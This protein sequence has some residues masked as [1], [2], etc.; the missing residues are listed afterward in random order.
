[1][2]T[3]ARPLTVLI[4]ALGGE[5]GGVLT[6]W[7]VAAANHCGFPAQST[8]IPGVAQRTGATTYYVEIVPVT[9]DQL[10][11]QR[12]VLSLQP[13]IGDVDVLL[14]SE[15][16]EAGRAIG[17][18]FVTPDRT[19]VIA[20]TSR[21]YLVVEK[22]AMA[23]GRYDS[24][25]LTKAIEDH[26]KQRVLFDMEALA[27]TSGTIVNAVM[28]GAIAGSGKLPIPVDAYEAAIRADGKAIEG[29]LRGFRAGFEAAQHAAN[30]VPAAK[31]KH[32]AVAK[33]LAALE[34]EVA[35]WPSAAREFLIEGVRRS[36][37]YQD[38]AYARLYL[39]RLAPIRAADEQGNV[40]GK[41]LREVA[42]HLAVRMSYED[43]IKVAEA[44]IHPARMR[45]IVGELKAAP[46]EPIVVAEFLKPGIEEMCQI[47]PPWLAPLILRLAERRG[48][49]GRV[50]FGM[51]VKTTSITGYLRVYMLAKLKR[52]RRGTWRYRQEQHAIES[53]LDMI[54][55]AAKLSPALAIEVVECARL[56]K[57]YGDTHQ[58]GSGNF[59]QIEQRIIRPV[60]AG[61][62]PTRN[63]I[64][65][66]ASARTAAL[67]DPEGESLA[68]C[69]AEI[70]SQAPL[71]I[72]AE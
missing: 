24:A 32:A 41:L 51:E 5:G 60:L 7:I 30:A 6:D 12:P 57:G 9:H 46:N 55:Q 48:W 52:W 59:A 37:R 44:K 40:G 4:A 69:L 2:T 39:D 71:R 21:S 67:T 19:T 42:R 17:N 65:A 11:G 16:M 68:K 26:A 54:A 20:S 53:W 62:M 28:L 29:N 14:A 27:K 23:D 13:G 66:I 22:M 38:A 34:C 33:Y 18:G 70:E 36:A 49:L 1:M 25:R 58:R 63:G 35:S 50:Y 61:R 64:D 3:L 15:L 47:M 72:A 56:I 45:R 8:S 43:V 31:S 10:A